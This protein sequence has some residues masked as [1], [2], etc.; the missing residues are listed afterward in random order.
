MRLSALN[1][2]VE[3][4]I[5]PRDVRLGLSATSG[6]GVM[7]SCDRRLLNRHPNSYSG[8]VPRCQTILT[9]PRHYLA[10]S[11]TAY[12]VLIVSSRDACSY[13]TAR[14]RDAY[15]SSTWNMNLSRKVLSFVTFGLAQRPVVAENTTFNPLAGIQQFPISSY[16]GNMTRLAPV[17]SISHGGGPMPV[18]G[19]PSHA[20]ITK[21]LQTKVPQILKLGTPEAPK[22]IVL[23]TA[24]WSTNKVHISSGARHE[25]LYD[26]YG[27]PDEAY[28][29]KHNAPGSPEVAGEVERVLKEAGID[30]TK[31]AERGKPISRAHSQY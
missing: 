30:C 27:F 1:F 31:D 29:L 15:Q 20:Q 21:S 5:T 17:L 13:K 25:L 18:L 11:S 26:Y 8:A 7:W 2:S 14:C 4:S 16:S 19:D 9:K 12:G 24:H 3:L 6:E 10:D 28:K 22:A 23:V